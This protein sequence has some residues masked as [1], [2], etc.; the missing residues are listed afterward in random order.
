MP[1][2][3]D[4]IAKGYFPAEI[5]AAFSP[6]PFATITPQLRG[7]V[8]NFAARKSLCAYHSIPR[9]QPN[10]RMLGIPNPLH[11]LKLALVIER[12]WAA[13][14]VHMKRSP[15]SLTRLEYDPASDRALKKAGDF[16]AAETQRLIRS[17][18]ARFVLKADLSRFYHS[19]YTHSIPWA[20]HGKDYAKAN[21]HN[22]AIYGNSIDTA[23][24]NTQDQQTL[25]IPVGPV[26]SDLLSELLGTALDLELKKMHPSLK[27]LRYVDDY[28]LFF[29]TRSEAEQ[30]LANLH[31]IANHFAVELNPLKTKISELPESV[32]PTWKAELR[33][34]IIREDKEHD[35][36]ITFLSRAYELGAK[37]RGN[38]VLKY[39]VK[40]SAGFTI[41]KD[42]WT[43]Y[44]SF[45]LG[46]LVAEPV[47]APTLAPLLVK[48]KEED[49]PLDQNKL[50]ATLTE[51]ASFHSKF[52]QGF[53]VAWA[54]RICKLF[55]ITLPDEVWP[56]VAVMDDSIVALLSL[57][58]KQA[59]LADALDPQLWS[60][61]MK[62]EH[63]YSENWL[64]AYEALHKG[65]LNSVDGTNYLATD[66][67][68]NQLTIN[69]VQ[70]YDAGNIDAAS[71]MDWLTGYV[72]L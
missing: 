22:P 52:K 7:G 44:E 19:L 55:E 14:E 8:D 41:S 27:G 1:L 48:Y 35:D 11:Q 20:L 61:Y 4:L 70:F 37:Y 2:Y 66:D 33:E 6:A 10:R 65:W 30:A 5:P 40:H 38:N 29:K 51:V 53:E 47:L 71:D 64:V 32:Q 16:G 36:L 57:D 59:G 39:A 9:I 18:T 24:R 34:S 56:D 58:L 60:T 15:Y 17:T 26:T 23:V 12:N 43:I 62:A 31:S 21:R 42:N 13:L 69:D 72:G 46:S 67:F 54:L 63:L 25:G 45:L 68:F 50:S 49:Y 3:Q 28:Y